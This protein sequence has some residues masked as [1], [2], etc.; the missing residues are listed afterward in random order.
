M[1]DAFLELII[2]LLMVYIFEHKIIPQVIIMF[3]TIYMLMVELA[4]GT[5]W[6]WILLLSTVVI[7]SSI[8]IATQDKEE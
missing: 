5:E 1:I 8:Q 2:L 3:I 4:A 6:R 7:Y